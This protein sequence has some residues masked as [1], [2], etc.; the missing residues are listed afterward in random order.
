LFL[1]FLLAFVQVGLANNLRQGESPDATP[2]PVEYEAPTPLPGVPVMLDGQVV[3]YV[4]DGI[5]DLTPV[6]RAL[7]IERRINDLATSPFHPDIEIILAESTDG[8]ELLAGDTSILTVTEQDAASYNMPIEEVAQTAAELIQAAIEESRQAA[9]VVDRVTTLLTIFGIGVGLAIAYFILHRLDLYYENKIESYNIEGEPRSTLLRT[10]YY[11]SGAWKMQAKRIVRVIKWV[12]F[13]LL[14]II[15]IPFVLELFPATTEL[16]LKMTALLTTPLRLSWT[17][18]GDNVDNF[19]IIVLLVLLFY[20]L[21]R[22]NIFIFKEIEDGNIRFSGFEPEW[23]PFTRR[24]LSFFLVILGV[25]VAFPFI[26]GSESP[27]LRGITVFLGALLTL[28]STSAVTNIIAGIIQTYTGAFKSGDIVQIAGVTGFVL[29]KKLI[30]TRVL[31]F[32]NEEVSIPNGSVLNSNVINYST[33]ARQD[34]L[35]LYTTITIG[36]DAPWQVVHNLLLAAAG[37]T[38]GILSVPEPFVLQKSLN[39]FHISYELNSHT[40]RPE[41]MPLIYSELHANIQDQF[42]QA[43]VEIMSPAFTALRDGGGTTIPGSFREAQGG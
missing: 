7:L 3:F 24:I 25:I 27:A 32:K 20:L 33:L 11:R 40:N 16:G 37:A 18:L 6:E 39:D 41:Q 35:V 13:I 36:Y 12:L 30:T 23:A 14:A 26:P 9:S 43:G 34:R 5:Y 19:F 8:I 1:L 31:T 10:Q 2:T 42:N 15:G 29:E 22:L 21:N 17:W 38:S 4:I 28:S